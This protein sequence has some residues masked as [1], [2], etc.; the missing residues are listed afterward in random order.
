MIW[1]KIIANHI[2]AKEEVIPSLHN[3]LPQL[4][5]INSNKRAKDLNGHEAH[6]KMINIVNLPRNANQNHK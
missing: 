2:S 1:E 3:V 6:E 4:N 5:N